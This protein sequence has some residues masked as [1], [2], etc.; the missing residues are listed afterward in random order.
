MKTILILH[1]WGSCAK[2]WNPVKELLKE[3]G[4]KI[5][6]PDLPGFGENSPPPQV[7]SI[8][9][10]VEWVKNYCEKNNLSLFFLLGHSFGGSVAVKFAIKYP[11]KIQKLFL[12]NCA[13]IRKKSLKKEII[14]KIANFFKKFDFLPFFDFFRK[15]FYRFIKSDCLYTK[16]IMRE[17]YLKILKEDISNDFSKISVPTVLIWGKKDNLTPL[18]DA[19]YIKGQISG[20]KL[21]ILP[22]IYHNPHRENPKALICIILNYLK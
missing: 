21:E 3:Q 16:G 10:Y 19:H 1:G 5:F 11:E 7:W 20:V 18:K 2:N 12:V 15:V 17:I 6:I 4:Y 9:D 22:G 8:D 14:K 13:G